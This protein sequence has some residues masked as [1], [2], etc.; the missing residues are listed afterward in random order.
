MADVWFDHGVYVLEQET[1]TGLLMS[2]F[3]SIELVFKLS[4]NLTAKTTNYSVR[5]HVLS[6]F[7]SNLFSEP[8]L[9]INHFFFVH[10]ALLYR[11]IVS[12]RHK[13]SGVTA[14]AVKPF[15]SA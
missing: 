1:P 15:A 11:F 6:D 7:F 10:P 3:Y 12:V 9:H 5:C 8:F 2:K 13:I 4:H 14:S